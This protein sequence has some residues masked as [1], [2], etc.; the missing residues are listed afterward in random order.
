MTRPTL[1]A[2][3]VVVALLLLALAWYVY[4]PAGAAPVA[5]VAL[6]A[7]AGARESQRHRA[8]LEATTEGAPPPPTVTPRTEVAG[9]IAELLDE[10]ERRL[11]G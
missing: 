4:G 11:G 7:S 2:A 6:A 5:G 10:E 9:T 3:G 8:R 1:I